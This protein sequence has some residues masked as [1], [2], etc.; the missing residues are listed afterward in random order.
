VGEVDHPAELKK[1]DGQDTFSIHS[2]DFCS[3]LD[4]AKVEESKKCS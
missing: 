4:Q 1:Y 2:L 3:T